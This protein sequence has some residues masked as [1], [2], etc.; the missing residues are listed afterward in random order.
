MT[1]FTNESTIPVVTLNNRWVTERQAM[2]QH[3]VSEIC[4][5][6]RC[7]PEQLSLFPL[8]SGKCWNC[9][10]PATCRPMLGR[11]TRCAGCERLGSDAE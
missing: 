5:C 1:N 11:L 10:A 3:P 8:A 7:V 9:S 2:S 6:E 4:S